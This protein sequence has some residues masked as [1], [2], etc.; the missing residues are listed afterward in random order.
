[1]VGAIASAINAVAGGGTLISFPFLTLGLRI[2][3][4]IA[5]ATNAAALWPGSLAGA[6]GFW[7]LI[8]KTGHYFRWLFVP[9]LLGSAA[10]AWLLTATSQRAFDIAIPFLIL[11]ASLLLAF[12]PAVKRWALGGRPALP[13]WVGMILQ[14]LVAVYGGYFGAGMGIMMLGAFA[15]YMEGNIHELNA[16][17]TW[18]G[19]II[20]LVA[21]FVFLFKGWILLVPFLA[22]TAGA[23][24]GG[25]L[26][27]KISQ[28]VDSEKM[29]VAIAAY[30]FAMVVYFAYRAFVRA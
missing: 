3:S 4:K 2:E 1:V 30:G 25:F 19:L 24:L 26:A 28:R 14:F 18:L 22:L 12:Q 6:F 10:G 11:I 5:N 9:T 23:I 27:A 13:E 15:L 20:N 21:S 8:S 29:R 7:N 16:V 17:K